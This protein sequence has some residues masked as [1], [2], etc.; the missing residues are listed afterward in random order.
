[1]NRL[2]LLGNG[3]DLAHGLKTSYNDFIVWYLKKVFNQA[4]DNQKF[5]DELLSIERI[6][7][8]NFPFGTIKSVD[9]LIDHFYSEG[10]FSSLVEN[11]QLKLPNYLNTFPNPFKVTIKLGFLY[12]LLKNCHVRNWVAIE[13][14]FYE[15]LIKN[16]VA[17]RSNWKQTLDELNEA[18]KQIII[19]LEEYLR[20]QQLV[21]EIPRIQDILKSLVNK[22]DVVLEKLEED[23]SPNRSM[24]LNF[25]Y[26][27]TIEHYL[28]DPAQILQ[29]TE[30]NYIHGKIDDPANPFIFGYGDEYDKK[31]KDLE[32]WIKDGFFKY[33][34]SFWYLR[35]SNYFRLV[36]FIESE[37]FQV[38]VLG[39]SCGLSDKTML[40]M[41]FEHAHCKSI[42]IFY[43]EYPNGNNFNRLTEDI[44]LLFDDKGLMRKKIV[45]LS[46]SSAL[47]GL[48][49]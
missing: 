20:G 10:G 15:E 27:A 8:A 30:I 36:R 18:M 21:S 32:E 35:T 43:Y 33:V 4:L 37:P 45:P 44:S 11:G 46:Q 9:G 26:T 5:E 2:I 17:R 31:Y 25:N 3:F 13:N 34:K 47:P 14:E 42:K 12:E 6:R 39:H 7:Q 23:I 49:K 29:D 28:N 16:L 41:I 48:V 24:I 22:D 38:Y 19:L 40:K 1:M